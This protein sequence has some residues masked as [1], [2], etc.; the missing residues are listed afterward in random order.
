[1]SEFDP[2]D[3]IEFFEE[4]A[5]MAEFEARLP[6]MNAESMALKDVAARH[7]PEAKR[8]VQRHMERKQ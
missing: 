6:R 4:R 1:M 2:H 8:M 7:G 5:A 3:V